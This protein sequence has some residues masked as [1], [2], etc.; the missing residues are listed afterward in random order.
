MHRLSIEQARLL[1][2]RAQA[3]TGP[4]HETLDGVVDLVETITCLPIDMTPAVAPSP[5]LV[6]W[7]RLGPSYDERDLADALVSRDLWEDMD[8]IRPASLLPAHRALMSRPPSPHVADWLEA[9][10]LFRAEVL[11]TLADSEDP[12]PSKAIGATPQVPWRSSG[13]N[14]N[15]SVALML[16]ILQGLGEVAID[17]RHGNQRLWTVAE[18]VLPD[19]EPIP[20]ERAGELLDERRLSGLGIARATGTEI[21]GEPV[22]VGEAGEA[23]VVDGVAGEWRV[24]PEALAALDSDGGD[25]R[26]VLLS[27]F[28]A[29]VRDRVRMVDLWG[30]DYTLE[31][32]KP[33]AKRRW[34]YFALPVLDGA[35]LVGKVDATT[36]RTRGHLAVTA[37]HEDGRWPRARRVRVAEAIDRLADCLGV[38]VQR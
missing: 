24:D 13:W 19:V 31:M 22:H 7:A 2:V 18:R 5:H 17:G 3:L 8:A 33:A 12:L 21:P 30:F 25:E 28:D 38:T 16:Q 15:R 26:A 29:I 10:D 20:V 14:E 34:G 4:R 23:A 36:D 32:Y 27:P 11:D 35:E 9:N 37:V 6:A 1:A